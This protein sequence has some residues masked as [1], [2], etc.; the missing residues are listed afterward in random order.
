MILLKIL[1]FHFR[2]LGWKTCLKYLFQIHLPDYALADNF[3]QAYIVYAGIRANNRIQLF[4]VEPQSKSML[5]AGVKIY[6][7]SRWYLLSSCAIKGNNVL[8]SYFMSLV[9]GETILSFPDVMKSSC[10]HR[11]LSTGWSVF[12]TV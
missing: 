12:F 11:L 6:S 8:N 7:H 4:E 1:V 5:L 10:L 2:N 9:I 3:S